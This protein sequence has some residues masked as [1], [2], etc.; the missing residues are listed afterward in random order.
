MEFVLLSNRRARDQL[1]KWKR[2]NNEKKDPKHYFQFPLMNRLRR[3]CCLLLISENRNAQCIWIFRVVKRFLLSP[4]RL[5]RSIHI[6]TQTSCTR[7]SYRIH[8]SQVIVS[9]L[10]V[11]DRLWTLKLEKKE[12]E[13]NALFLSVSIP[14][15]LSFVFITVVVQNDLSCDNSPI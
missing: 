15:L 2:R 7:C 3:C 8:G 6:L 4:L 9:E 13:I 5:L 1:T 14:I 10:C 12:G 11:I